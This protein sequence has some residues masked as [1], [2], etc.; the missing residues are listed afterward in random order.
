MAG[1]M[2]LVGLLI[3]VRR[4]KELMALLVSYAFVTVGVGIITAYAGGPA[5]TRAHPEVKTL[6]QMYLNL[7]DLGW[8]ALFLIPL[9]FPDG[10]FVP[11]WTGWLAP[12]FFLY[13]I[14]P[15]NVIPLPLWIAGS[16][17]VLGFGMVLLSPV[18][19]YRR[20]SDAV[21]RE[22][23]RWVLFGFMVG[24]G[25]FIALVLVQ[26]LIPWL[27]AS[28]SHF[29]RCS[30]PSGPTTVTASSR[31]VPCAAS[32]AC[33]KRTRTPNRASRAA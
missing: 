16:L 30:R 20:V 3:F 33:R 23:T 24:L 31:S 27:T 5:L 28:A 29:A 10:R 8:G 13:S 14:L 32:T 19:R 15:S 12:A 21:Q 4:S 25:T 2:F 22:Q 6:L 17:S 26:G 7:A 1:V 11:R 18:Y 9:I